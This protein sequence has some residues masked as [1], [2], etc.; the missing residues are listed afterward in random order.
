MSALWQQLNAELAALIERAGRSLVQVR[1][2]GRGAGAGTIWHEQGLIVTAAHVVDHLPLWVA[3]AD[4]R[5]LP[6]RLLARDATRD[7]AAL[8]VEAAGLPTIT[9]G[10]SRGLRPGQLVLA[11]GHPWGVAGA[12][13]AGAVIGVGADWREAPA[14]G[15]EWIAVGLRL[16]PGSSGGPLVDDRGRLVGVNTMMAGPEVGMA[17]PV[18]LVKAFLR[19]ALAAEI[20]A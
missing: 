13:T 11:L 4:G 9:V 20:A 5:T 15:G 1:S 18:H 6:A 16:R 19:E 2:G 3:L 10:D 17:V 14:S 8:A 12:A 7:L